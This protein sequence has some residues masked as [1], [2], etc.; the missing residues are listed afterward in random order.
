M[1]IDIWLYRK[2]YFESRSKAKLAV[3][4]GIVLV[5]G[6]KVKP[7]YEVKAE[8]TVEV[9]D[10]G[11]PAGYY[12]LREIERRWNL[13][14]GV[15]KVLDIGSSAGGFLIYSSE[16]ASEV[17]GIEF[18]RE[19]EEELRRIE[20][21]RGN[22]RVFIADAF[23]FN[24]SILPE[25]D[26]ILCDL[27]LEPEDAEKAL[28]RFAPKLKEKGKILFVSKG[29]GHEFEGFEVISSFKSDEKREWYYLLKSKKVF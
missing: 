2:G 15:E 14:D 16:R 4:K 24:T 27:T 20:R 6:K 1:R 23:T 12:K 13:F 28:I 22:V 11:K 29:K 10:S 21:E 19:F 7:S 26:L 8:D 3:K 17:I 5:N 18:S 9:L 25:F